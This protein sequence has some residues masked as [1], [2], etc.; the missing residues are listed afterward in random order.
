M[1]PQSILY[2]GKIDPV[3]RPIELRAGPLTMLFEPHT[4]FLRHIRLGDHEVVRALYAAGRDQ[5]WATIPPRV[6]NLKSEIARDSFRL[7]FEVACRCGEIDY[8]WQGTM[9]GEANGRIKFSFDGL[10]RSDFLRNRIGICI[11]HPIAECAGIPC[12]VEHVDGRVEQGNFP[13][14]IS[15]YQPFR[16]IRAIS[17]A[18]ATTGI[19]AQLEVEGDTFEMEDQRNWSDA[20]FKTYC[21]PLALPLPAPVKTGDRA[22]QAVTLGLSGPVRPILPVNL[23]RGPQLSISTTPVVALPPI[24]LCAASHGKP[25]SGRDIERL[26]WLRLWHLRLDLNLSSPHYRADLERVTQEADQLGVGLHLALTFSE[27][28][29]EELRLLAGHLD[30]VKPRV[31]F[32]IILHQTENPATEQTVQRARPVL[33]KY[34]PSAL[35]AAGTKDFFT[36]V[37]RVRLAPGAT[38]FVCYSTNP[39]VHAFDNTTLVENLAGQAYN[40]ESARTFSARPVVVS[41]VT[42]RIRNHAAARD[43]SAATL[44]ELPSDVDPRQMSL[45]G[46]GWTL[47]SIARL[48]TTG[49]V[50]SLTYFETTGWRG[51]METEAGPPLPEKFPSAPGTVFP[52]FHVLAD[53]AEFPGKQIYPTHSSHPLLVAGLTLFDTRG[54]RRIL[55]ANLTGEPQDVKIKTGTCQARV[56]QLDETSAEAAMRDP[57]AFRAQADAARASVAGKIELQ[58]LPYAIAR[59]DI[60]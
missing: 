7:T 48:A 21:T 2:D 31:L 15:P 22:Q 28:A 34:A 20:S 10:A 54:R 19:R 26:K 40:V 4:A 59:L 27:N 35:L 5:N 43:E 3:P 24:G 57:E 49:F 13:T 25:L 47:G 16:D 56:R 33:Q 6:A 60:G 37:N 52:M 9:S 45:F 1:T 55:V 29:D 50:H 18:V 41:P 30:Q 39:Q 36:E 12:A 17:Y 42:L 14:A 58:L 32:W 51:V 23:G 53:I 11:L 44:S 8:G 38:S 46:G